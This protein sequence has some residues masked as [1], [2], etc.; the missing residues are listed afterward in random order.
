MTGGQ[1]GLLWKLKEQGNSI[2]DAG[3]VGGY[4][5]IIY[6]CST[7]EDK[8]WRYVGL[9]GSYKWRSFFIEGSLTAG[10]GTYSNPQG[11]L[12]VG[13]VFKTSRR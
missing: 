7:K 10:S 6:E 5:E 11:L 12:Q 13:F 2:L 9:A 4:T 3:L 1:L 8:L